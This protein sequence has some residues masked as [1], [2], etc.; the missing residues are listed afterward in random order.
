MRHVLPMSMLI[1]LPMSMRATH[2]NPLPRW[3]RGS[4]RVERSIYLLAR[5]LEI[6]NAGDSLVINNTTKNLLSPIEG[7]D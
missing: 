1:V 5:L 4:P 3:G 2:P 6:I 7:E